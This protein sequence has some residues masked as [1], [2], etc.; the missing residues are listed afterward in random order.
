MKEGVCSMCDCVSKL[1]SKLRKL[2]SAE[3]VDIDNYDV[4]S[5]RLYVPIKI[6]LKWHIKP[7]EQMFMPKF[8]S[9]CG[10]RYPLMKKVAIEPMI[11]CNRAYGDN[12]PNCLSLRNGI[13]CA[14]KI[15]K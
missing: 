14:E 10:V 8:C 11:F 12:S 13:Y 1:T 9:I 3:F 15:C 2:Y 7:E 4:E 6:S 5:G